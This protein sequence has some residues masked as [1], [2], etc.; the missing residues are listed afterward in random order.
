MA[1]HDLRDSAALG[2]ALVCRSAVLLF[3]ARR[4]AGVAGEELAPDMERLL[5]ALALELEERGPERAR[6]V[7]ARAFDRGLLLLS[8][9]LDGNVI[10]LLPP[11]VG[12]SDDE[13]RTF[14]RLL[15]ER[16]PDWVP[17]VKNHDEASLDKLTDAEREEVFAAFAPSESMRLFD[18]ER[19]RIAEHRGLRRVVLPHARPPDHAVHGGD[20]HDGGAL[21][22][23]QAR[24]RRDGADHRAH[25]CPGA[26]VYPITA[27]AY[28]P[29]STSTR[30]SRTAHSAA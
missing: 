15:R 22:R 20:V 30:P 10:R 3:R 24:Q 11:Y 4:K 5:S 25:R 29:S 2:D 23:A 18:R 8:C 7:V 17:A 6:A 1:S 12:S 14:V 16:L 21:R 19:A 26:G 13:Y 27:S 28:S 9:G